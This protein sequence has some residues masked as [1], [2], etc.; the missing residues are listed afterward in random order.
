MD[1]LT[2]EICVPL[3]KYMK[4]FPAVHR[5]HPFETAMLELTWGTERYKQALA[6]VDSL[7]KSILQVQLQWHACS[8]P[9]AQVQQF[10]HPGIS[11]R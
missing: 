7:R 8:L 1:T 5:L 11:P 6:K 3:G 10:P 9:L 4:G 2:K